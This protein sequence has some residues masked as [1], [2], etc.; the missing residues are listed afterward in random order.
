MGESLAIAVVSPFAWPPTDEDGREVALEAEALAARGHRVTLITS[1]RDVAAMAD[2]RRRRDAVSNGEPE[3]AIAPTGSVLVMQVGRALTAGPGRRVPGPIDLAAALETLL[4]LVPF[5]IV[6]LHEPL[7]PSPALA[8]LRHATGTSVVTFHRTSQLAGVAFVRPLVDRALGRVALRIAQGPSAASTLA[9]ILPGEY[10]VVTP[11]PDPE[12]L[13]RA[14]EGPGDAVLVV[15]RDRDRAGVR[16]GL[17]VLRELGSAPITVLGPP[18]APWRTKAAIP[19][20]LRASVRVIPDTGPEARAAA[21]ASCAIV[22]APNPTDDDAAIIRAALERGLVVLAARSPETEELIDDREN[23]VLLTAF[24]TVEW[25]SALRETRG[26]PALRARI[27]MQAA[28]VQRDWD[29]VAADLEAH[30][31]GLRAA[32]AH[33]APVRLLADLDVR[34]A[35]GQDAAAIFAACLAR[36]VAAVALIQTGAIDAALTAKAAAPPELTVVVGQEIRSAE[37][38]VIAL[39]LDTPIA[40]GT[41]LTDVAAAVALQGG[42]LI[43]PHP[44]SPDAPAPEV[45][46]A[47]GPAVAAHALVSGPP[48]AAVD[49]AA[50]VAHGMGLLVLAGSGAR[51][52]TEIGSPVLRMLPFTDAASFLHA[53]AEA[54][55]VRRRRVLLPRS[56]RPS[57]QRD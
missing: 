39:F 51:R 1:G 21:L 37:G 3:A 25:A 55:V 22:L 23:G 19:L 38:T 14:P 35:P 29:D 5:D 40:G 10:A 56:P 49:E 9:Q 8:A 46:R 31:I 12:L 53:L 34:I 47:L 13:E 50:R 20:A 18:D 7:S 15:A 28:S 42:L 52:V 30:F 33:P 48:A 27:G 16:F 32:D 26:D 41:S 4:S 2:A 57:F 44:D 6:H 43:A 11:A 17:R 36:D 24:S 45:L 54:Q